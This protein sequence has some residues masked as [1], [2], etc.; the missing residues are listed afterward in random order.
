M[1][2]EQAERMIERRM[3]AL[4]ARLMRWELTQAEYDAEVLALDAWAQTLRPTPSPQRSL[5]GEG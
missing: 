2:E 5:F 3:D 4:D 1:T